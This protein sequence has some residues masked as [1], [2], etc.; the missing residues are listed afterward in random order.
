MW[1]IG[2]DESGMEVLRQ[3]RKHR[4]AEVVVSATVDDP[5][6]VREGLIEAVDYIENITPFNVNRLAKRIHPDII[7]ID[8]GAGGRN[9]GRVTGGV[10][11]SESLL[12]EISAVSE[13]PC[14]V[15]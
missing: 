4:R 13:Y 7:L 8:S 9:I 2:A 15:L 11:F 12:Y 3:L 5:L 6:A 1:L 14:M 10:A